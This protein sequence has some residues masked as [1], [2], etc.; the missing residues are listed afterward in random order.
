MNE[1][2]IVITPTT[3]AK[4]LTDAIVS[5]QNQT[6]KTHHLLVVDGLQFLGPVNEVLR[7]TEYDP[8]T[9]SI[10]SIPF[11]TGKD[12]YYGH[13]ILAAFPHL[14][15][16]DYILFLDQDNYYDNTHVDN[17]VSDLEY[18][19]YDFVYS[20]RKIMSKEGEYLLND[21]CESLGIWPIYGNHKNGYLIDTSAYCFKNQFI[22]MVAHLWDHGWGGDRRF[23]KIIT[24]HLQNKNH[25][26]TGNYTLNYRLGGNDGS[27]NEQ[28]FKNGLESVRKAYNITGLT[29]PWN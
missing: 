5:V 6:Y 2:A 16:H 18:N 9:L 10:C 13:R 27:V 29:F 26:T 12:G 8:E 17:M 20:L 28:F 19:G 7:K 3:G 21:D 15:N 25:G 14:L 22:R 1:K 11:N 4:E 23:Y 24:Q